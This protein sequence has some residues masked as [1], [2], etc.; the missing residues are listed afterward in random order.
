MYVHYYLVSIILFN[1]EYTVTVPD[2]S[3]SLFSVW[4]SRSRPEKLV[5]TILGSR[6]GRKK[7]NK[8]VEIFIFLE[9]RGRTASSNDQKTRSNQASAPPE[10][11]VNPT[12]PPVPGFVLGA[13]TKLHSL[14]AGSSNIFTG[15]GRSN[16][17][18]VNCR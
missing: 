12:F 3:M 13:D 18:K 7:K 5:D 6:E 8:V 16:R 11:L 17:G 4:G 9:S 15:L 10:I 1:F 14:V 2:I